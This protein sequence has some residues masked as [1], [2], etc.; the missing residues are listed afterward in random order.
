[1]SKQKVL[2]VATVLRG[3]ILVFHLPYMQWFREQGFEVHCCAGNDTGE[4]NPVVPHCDRYI[5]LAFERSPLNP[6][7]MDAYRQLKAL[8]DTEG[9][10][11]I[12]CHTPVGGMLTRLAARDARKGGTRVLY[13][14][15]GFHFYTGAP[16]LNWLLFYPAEK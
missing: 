5:D 9:Y 3:H 11:L 2:F 12:H 8:I 15:H 4:A 13:T 1:M 7:N 16:P 10:A 6:C 14:A